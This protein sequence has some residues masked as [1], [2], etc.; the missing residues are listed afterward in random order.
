MRKRRRLSWCSSSDAK[1]LNGTLNLFQ[2]L[3]GQ[4]FPTVM[5]PRLASM[6]SFNIFTVLSLH[7]SMPFL[8]PTVDCSWKSSNLTRNGTPTFHRSEREQIAVRYQDLI[9]APGKICSLMT[10]TSST[11]SVSHICLPFVSFDNWKD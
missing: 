3:E 7:F 6:L 1:L 11:L 9:N 5:R 10:S 4:D 8:H 2:I